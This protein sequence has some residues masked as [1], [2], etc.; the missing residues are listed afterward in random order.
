MSKPNVFS[1]PYT[2]GPGQLSTGFA[3]WGVVA[4]KMIYTHGPKDLR[5]HSEEAFHP[6]EILAINKRVTEIKQNLIC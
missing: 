3:G 4:G 5:A 6:S 1:R 2:A